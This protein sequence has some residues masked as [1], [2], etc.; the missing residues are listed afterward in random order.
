MAVNRA[1]MSEEEFS[2]A[3]GD[4]I[5]DFADGSHD[6]ETVVRA[7]GLTF[8]YFLVQTIRGARLLPDE[9]QEFLCFTLTNINNAT[10]NMLEHQDRHGD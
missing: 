5:A 3:M 7:V 2:T 6:F 10:L 1:P 8:S 9:V 4:L